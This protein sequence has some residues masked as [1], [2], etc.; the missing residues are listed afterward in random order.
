MEHKDAQERPPL[1]RWM[2]RA[3]QLFPWKR[4]LSVPPR[5]PPFRRTRV[6]LGMSLETA[7]LSLMIP[8][9]VLK[10]IEDGV[11]GIPGHH[12]AFLAQAM[13]DYGAFLGIPKADV[14]EQIAHIPQDQHTTPQPVYLSQTFYDK[15]PNLARHSLILGASVCLSYSVGMMGW[16]TFYETGTTCTADTCLIPMVDHLHHIT[17]TSSQEKR[18]HCPIGGSCHEG[19]EGDNHQGHKRPTPKPGH[20]APKT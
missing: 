9:N 20:K 2:A 16:A 13:K 7:C 17:A 18:P 12:P 3:R 15:K 19:H 8:V 4:S 11:Y 5:T 1:S 10:K 6:Q 14:D